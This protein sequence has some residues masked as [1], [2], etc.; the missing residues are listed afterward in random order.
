MSSSCARRR[1]VT[2]SSPSARISP[3]AVVMITARPRGGFA[4]RSRRLRGSGVGVV[5]V[6]NEHVCYEQ[7]RHTPWPSGPG[8]PGRFSGGSCVC[9]FRARPTAPVGASGAD[10]GPSTHANT[11]DR[12]PRPPA[13]LRGQ[14]PEEE[15]HDDQ[16]CPQG[17]DPR[18][19]GGDGESY[20]VAA[21]S[22]Q[23]ATPKAEVAA[24]LAVQRWLPADSLDLPCPCGGTCSPGRPA[25]AA[26]RST[27][28]W[29]ATRAA[30][31]RSRCGRT[32]TTASA[33]RPRTG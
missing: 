26:T 28:T 21:R 1:M 2:R 13:G 22:L 9:P 19:D 33:A 25:H 8:G 4:G 14:A 29:P 17:R 27:A 20:N 16:P 30:R 10:K 18:A 31:T 6:R 7:V 15:A 23:Q 11:A 12:S 3:T 32:A 24:A 5:T